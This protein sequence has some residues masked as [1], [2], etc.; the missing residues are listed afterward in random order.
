MTQRSYTEVIKDVL[1]TTWQDKET[2]SILSFLILNASFMSVELLYGYLSNSLSLIGDG[3]HMMVDSMALFV[4]LAAAYISKRDTR[5]WQ[6][7]YGYMKIESLS[8]LF[9]SLFLIAV[10]YSLFLKSVDRLQN[11]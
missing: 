1:R 6:L 9:N 11:P 8:A 2:R 4:G 5:T 10:S 3:F 7:P